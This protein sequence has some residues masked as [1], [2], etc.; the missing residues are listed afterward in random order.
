[1]AGID[2]LQIEISKLMEVFLASMD[3][4]IPYVE[5]ES[6]KKKY[7]CFVL[8]R[9]KKSKND[10]HFFMKVGLNICTPEDLPLLRNYFEKT[11]QDWQFYHPSDELST[12][13]CMDESESTDSDN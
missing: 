9:L 10:K 2:F 5:V 3:N 12:D 8:M 11:V 7:K 13:P 6:T 1:M 4:A